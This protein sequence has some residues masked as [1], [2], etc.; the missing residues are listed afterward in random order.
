M[1]HVTDTPLVKSAHA[2]CRDVGPLNLQLVR[3]IEE[4]LAAAD[5]Q[6]RPAPELAATRPP[7]QFVRHLGFFFKSPVGCDVHDLAEQ[8]ALLCRH[9]LSAA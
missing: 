3:A 8:F 7:L 5:S 1:A 2:L 9:V 4:D 6:L